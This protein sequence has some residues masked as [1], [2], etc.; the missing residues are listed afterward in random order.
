MTGLRSIH[1]SARHSREAGKPSA[2]GAI[3]VDG[4]DM[5]PPPVSTVA[6]WAQGADDLQDPYGSL[7]PRRPSAGTIAQPRWSLAGR[8][9]AAAERRSGRAV[10]S[11]WPDAAALSARILRASASGI[12]IARAL[13]PRSPA[14]HRR[15]CLSALDVSV[16]R[17]VINLLGGP[18]EREFG[19]SPVHQPRPVRWSST[20]TAGGDVSRHLVDEVGGRSDP[21][22]PAASPQQGAAEAAPIADPKGGT[23]RANAPSRRAAEPHRSTARLPVPTA[24]SGIAG[25]RCRW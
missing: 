11:V 13:A 7:N 6:R 23:G 17:Q 12:G 20:P 19:V 1:Q 16:Q 8:S 24:P 21:A 14:D 15:I 22:Q 4:V 18:K 25:A 9:D 5:A 10:C 2:G 3:L